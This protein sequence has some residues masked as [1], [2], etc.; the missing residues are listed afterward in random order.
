MSH[1]P[2]FC[3]DAFYYRVPGVYKRLQ[4]TGRSQ[5]ADISAQSPAA[6]ID[7]VTREHLS[8]DVGELET[9]LQDAGS[10][11]TDGQSAH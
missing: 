3:V 11:V 7:P 10:S 8:D 4:A 1:E 9:E 6:V 5:K 2:A